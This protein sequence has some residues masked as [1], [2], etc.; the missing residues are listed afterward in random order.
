VEHPH[1]LGKESGFELDDELIQTILDN[2][3]YLIP[4]SAISYQRTSPAAEVERTWARDELLGPWEERREVIRRLHEAGVKL[5]AGSDAGGFN[6]PFDDY[7]W[8]FEQ[9][10]DCGLTPMEA[11]EAGTR[12]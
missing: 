4:T 12:I 1:F 2:D 5:V 6:V 10:V 3:V 11:I 7:A 8:E 9:F